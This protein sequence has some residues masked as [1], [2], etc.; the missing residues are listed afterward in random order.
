M[1][2]IDELDE[3]HAGDIIT[4]V[5]PEFVTSWSSQWLHNGSAFA[6]KAKLLYRPHTA[7]VSV[8]IHTVGDEDTKS[9]RSYRECMS[10]LSAV[11]ASARRSPSTCVQRARRHRDRPTLRVVPPP[12]RRL[13]GPDHGGRRLRP[14]P[15]DRGRYHAD[16]RGRRRHQRRQLEHPDRPRRPRDVR[17]QACRRPHLRPPPSVD[18]RTPGIA[19]VASVAWTS[20]RVLRRICPASE[21]RRVDRPLA[22]FALVERRC[23]PLGR[24]VGRPRSSRGCRSGGGARSIRR[25]VDTLAGTL[26]QED[27]VAARRRCA[28]DRCRATRRG[29]AADHRRERT[30]EGDHRRRRQA[31]VATW[32]V[33]FTNPATR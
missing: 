27:D 1:Q 19:T 32:P 33:S 18:L 6:L 4:V 22:K 10:S 31:S 28:A 9:S 25:S 24:Y 3:Q 20:A 16:S 7:V 30:D 23:R 17:C 8:P 26:L 5:I 12:R 13:Q 21:R 29:A 11:A 15:A 2:F 14:R